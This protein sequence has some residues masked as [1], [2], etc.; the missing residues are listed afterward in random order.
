M[1]DGFLRSLLYE[2]C[3]SG[4]DVGIERRPYHRNCRCAFH[5]KSLAGNCS[6]AF[7]KSKKVSYPIRRSWSEGCLAMATASL[8]H[9]SPSSAG[10]GKRGLE[11]YKEEEED[12]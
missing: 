1:A 8:V 11:S 10:F 6:G 9:S 2:G 7:P 5:D 12:N 3:I 4:C